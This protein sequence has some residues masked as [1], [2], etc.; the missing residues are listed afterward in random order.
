MAHPSGCFVSLN[1]DEW[2]AGDVILSGSL[3]EE[4]G[5]EQITHYQSRFSQDPEI[6][7]W[8]HV[9]IYAGKGVIWEALPGKDVTQTEVQTWVSRQYSIHRMRFKSTDFD[10]AGLEQAL[11]EQADAEYKVNG[12]IKALLAARASRSKTPL[13]AWKRSY[14]GNELICSVFVE[15]VIRQVAQQEVFRGMEIVIP[16]DF[17][18]HPEFDS[19]DTHWCL[20]M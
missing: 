16:M 8:W 9:A 7:R 3:L 17:A 14:S 2:V 4:A 5:L 18:C 6:Y 10:N 20:V 11:A 12:H 19:T 15:R 13:P 1:F